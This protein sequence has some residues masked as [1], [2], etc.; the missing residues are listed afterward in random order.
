MNM[1]NIYCSFCQ[2][3]LQGAGTAGNLDYSKAIRSE[4]DELREG[5][6]NRSRDKNF[7]TIEQAR[8]NKLKLDWENF[9]PKKPNFIG[10]KTIEVE[11]ETLSDIRNDKLED[12]GI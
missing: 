7:L 9:T 6:L 11:I 3:I 1:I 2:Y 12:L 8:L 4:Y 10:S 5:Y